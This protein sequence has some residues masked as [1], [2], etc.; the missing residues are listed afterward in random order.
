MMNETGVFSEAYKL[1]EKYC[2]YGHDVGLKVLV[3]AILYIL[4]SLNKKEATKK[5]KHIHFI[6]NQY[7]NDFLMEEMEDTN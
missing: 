1:R 7:E 5:L 3:E 2:K 6:L 4:D